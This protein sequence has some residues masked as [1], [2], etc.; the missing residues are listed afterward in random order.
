[1][2]KTVAPFINTLSKALQP[3][4]QF[5]KDSTKTYAVSFFCLSFISSQ[6][7]T[8]HSM[9]FQMAQQKTQKLWPNFR[10]FITQIGQC[11]LMRR[12]IAIELN[13]KA[14]SFFFLFHLSLKGSF[15]V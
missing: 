10:D 6:K 12:Q 5:P 3:T 14:S 8:V 4:T 15:R 7:A 11:Q 13:V 2:N 9:L 1:M